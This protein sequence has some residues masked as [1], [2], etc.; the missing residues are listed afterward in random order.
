MASNKG[1][2]EPEVI[3]KPLTSGILQAFQQEAIEIGSSEDDEVNAVIDRVSKPSG[4]SLHAFLHK[5]VKDLN[6]A[7]STVSEKTEDINNVPSLEELKKRFLAVHQQYKPFLDEAFREDGPSN[8]IVAIEPSRKQ[9]LTPKVRRDDFLSLHKGNQLTETIVNAWFKL[10]K[11]ASQQGG[12]SILFVSPY[13]ARALVGEFNKLK[14]NSKPDYQALRKKLGYSPSGA[15]I[16]TD[17]H[18]T[19]FIPL[20]LSGQ[21]FQAMGNKPATIESSAFH[22]ISIIVQVEEVTIQVYDTLYEPNKKDWRFSFLSALNYLLQDTFGSK[23]DKWRSNW[24]MEFVKFVNQR[25]GTND[26]GVFVCTQAY[27]CFKNWPWV[28]SNSCMSAMRK[29]IA[30]SIINHDIIVGHEYDRYYEMDGPFWKQNPFP[31]KDRQPIE[32]NMDYPTIEDWVTSSQMSTGVDK[33]PADVDVVHD[34]EDDDKKPKGNDNN[35]E[36]GEEKDDPGSPQDED[37]KEKVEESNDQGEAND[38]EDDEDKNE[39]G[40]SRS[41]DEEEKEEENNDQEDANDNGDDEDN[42]EEG[43]VKL[44]MKKKMTRN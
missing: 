34:T 5:G 35:N 32:H 8:E 22:W 15:K 43:T 6:K 12:N 21:F 13:S 14:K 28:Y 11:Q 39:E 31:M 7:Y 27:F 24:K 44:K 38:N 25:E 40:G 3:T 41:E 42:N 9:V 36:G 2:N 33:K 29:R 23:G 18:K 26:C 19:W 10:L 4:T 20:S 16:Q 1:E 17:Q 37:E 30:L